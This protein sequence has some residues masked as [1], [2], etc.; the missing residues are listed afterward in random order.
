MIRSLVVCL[1][2]AAIAGSALGA[3]AVENRFVGVGP[4]VLFGDFSGLNDAF[5]RQGIGKLSSTHAV[6][7]LSGFG[8]FG[9]AV[10]G[11]GG[12]DGDQTVSSDSLT[13]KVT[14]RGGE[15]NIGYCVVKQAHLLV[16]PVL[17]IGGN[18]YD[19]ALAP[20]NSDF[21]S[22]N[23]MLQHP[24]RTSSVS[25]AALLLSPQL[26]VTVPIAF[27]GLQLRGGY[28]YQPASSKWELSEGGQLTEG[29]SMARGTPFAALSVVFGPT[30]KLH[31]NRSND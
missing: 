31:G 21:S 20:V 8:V 19:I 9:R 13:A 24:R 17:G 11:F 3:D 27:V 26:M 5:A 18:V 4:T 23:N 14:I 6:A 25:S 10:F 28:Q 22:F 2:T 1:L 29:P 16:A 15:F 12:W 7:G 30:R